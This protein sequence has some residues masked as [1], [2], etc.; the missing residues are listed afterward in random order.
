MDKIN[1]HKEIL[2]GMHEMYKKKNEDYG[3]S[4]DKSMDK[5]GMISSLIRLTD[6][7]N[8]FEQLIEND[9]NVADESIEDTLLD[10]ANYAI[11]TAMWNRKD[12]DEDNFI[13]GERL[14]AKGTYLSPNIT[15][16]VDNIE[17]RNNILS[18][19]NVSGEGI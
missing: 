1:T 10:L 14:I 18:K 7:M 17:D 19:Y 9:A 16:S 11:M 12:E 4:F 3:D 2:D 15:W 5:F 8:R 6:K 13:K